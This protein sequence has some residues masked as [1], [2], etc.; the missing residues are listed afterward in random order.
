MQS[1]PVKSGVKVQS[2]PVKSGVME[3]S[4]AAK[5]QSRP[6]KSSVTVQSRPLKSGLM[7]QARPVK[8]QS[9]PVRSGVMVQSR[10]VKLVCLLDLILIDEASA[11]RLF[12]SQKRKVPFSMAIG[13]WELMH[14]CFP[15]HLSMGTARTK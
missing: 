13:H 9:R 1:R 5:V 10:P 2:K 14:E 3:Q 6:L 8:V 11:D 7:V 4:R 12:R 15:K